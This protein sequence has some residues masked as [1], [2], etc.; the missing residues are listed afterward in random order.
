MALATRGKVDPVGDFELLK[1]GVDKLKSHIYS[2][3]YTLDNAITDAAKAAYLATLI[4]KGA[5]EIEKYWGSISEL[6][7]MSIYPT[8][9]KEL[10]KIRRGNPEAYYYWVKTSELLM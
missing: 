10:A 5:T 3:R 2:G 7:D 8:L 6:K 1:E 9:S 4:D